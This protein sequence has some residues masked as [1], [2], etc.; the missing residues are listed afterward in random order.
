MD[1]EVKSHFAPKPPPPPKEIIPLKTTQHFVDHILERPSV[2]E[3]RRK[4]SD[5]DRSIIKLYNE[6]KGINAGKQFPAQRTDKA[7]DPPSK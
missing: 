7:I 1:A 6:E 2:H 4:Q 5:Y 3:E